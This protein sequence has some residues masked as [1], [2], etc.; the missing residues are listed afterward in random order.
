MSAPASAPVRPDVLRRAIALLDVDRRR[1]V[2]AVLLGS[3]ALGS[4]V[5]LAAVSAWLI[6]RASQ[7]PPVLTL[8]VATVSVRAFGIS[9][10]VF[11]YVERLAS[12][13]T[14]LRG[15]VNLRERAYARLAG[16]G[17]D[18]VLALRRG[19]IVARM[20]AVELP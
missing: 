18:T 11:R 10:G 16:A 20:G 14:A 12:H 19:D 8:S 2:S 9:R 4:A 15:V 3:L 13:D 1:V 17:A 6:A 7:M 5:A